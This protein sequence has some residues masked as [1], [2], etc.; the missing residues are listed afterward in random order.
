MVKLVRKMQ[1]KNVAWKEKITTIRSEY[2]E[3]MDVSSNPID[4]RKLMFELQRAMNDD[5]I[6]S[7]GVGEHQ[8]DVAHFIKFSKPRQFIN[9]GGLGTMGFGFPAAIGAKLANQDLDVICVDG[10]GSFAMTMQELATAKQNDIKVTVVI[11]NNEH[12]GMVRAWND[13]FYEGRRSQVWLGKVPD[14]AKVAEAYGL[15][16]INVEK[17]GEIAEALKRGLKSEETAVINV[18][19]KPDAIVLPIVPSGASNSNMHGGKI[20]K[21]YFDR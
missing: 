2:R 1:W 7:V 16:G 6:V 18:H 8:M 21:G 9:S 19:T 14:F 12:L 11:M 3:E 5:T 17:P 15:L 10:D 4:P 20:T 13:L